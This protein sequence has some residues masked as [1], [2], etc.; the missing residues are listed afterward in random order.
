M[1]ISF[2]DFFLLGDTLTGTDVSGCHSVC[3]KGDMRV[4]ELME[5]K[6]RGWGIIWRV[7]RKERGMSWKPRH[8]REVIMLPF[9]LF[10]W[11][12]THATIN[13]CHCHALFTH[14]MRF[15]TLAQES[16]D[17]RVSFE[18]LWMQWVRVD[19]CQ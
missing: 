7:K 18:L 19:V 11:F 12:F 14:A 9:T 3:F 6:C 4:R 13:H 17:H 2:S 10:I 1:S 16:F 8:P 15:L 5:R